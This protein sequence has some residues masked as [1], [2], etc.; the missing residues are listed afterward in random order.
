MRYLPFPPPFFLLSSPQEPKPLAYLQE[1]SPGAYDINLEV[2]I[3]GKRP[4]LFL[5]IP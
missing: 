5:R 4:Y 2:A 3:Q 1:N